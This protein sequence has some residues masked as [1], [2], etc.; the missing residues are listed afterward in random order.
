MHSLLNTNS[1]GAPHFPSAGY[2]TD[3][4]LLDELSRQLAANT[5]RY[6][7][8]SNVNNGQRPGGAMRIAKPSSANNSPR[9]ALLQSRRRTMIGDAGAQGRF[10]PQQF[11]TPYLPTPSADLSTEAVYQPEK[12]SARPLSWHPSSQRLPQ[13]YPYSTQ[14]P[15]MLYPGSAYNDCDVFASFQQLPPTPAVYSGY[16]S[17]SS[18]FSPLSLPYSNIE[19]Q[20]Y[21]SPAAHWALPPQPTPV[22]QLD[23]ASRLAPMGAVSDIPYQTGPRVVGGTLDWNTFAAQGFDRCTAP[24]TP[25]DFNQSQQPQP[26]LDAEDSIPFQ[27]LEDDE[28]EGEILYGM[29]LYD[30]PDKS[31]ADSHLDFHRSAVFSLLG[32]SEYPEPTGKGLKLEDAWE[33]PASDDEEDNAEDEDDADGDD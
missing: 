18:T 15:A 26:K 19:S 31:V 24:P 25:E 27:P 9:S 29:G 17:P 16:N 11:E 32:G 6:S 23:S 10:N 2:A 5:R 1:V 22:D 7:R 4:A 33:P 21:F 8:G 28:S 14:Q 13:S 30:P 12:R 3:T 20:Q